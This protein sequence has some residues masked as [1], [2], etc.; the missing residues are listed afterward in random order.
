[1]QNGR[2]VSM[3]G[4]CVSGT[5]HFGDQGSQKIRTGTHRFGT[6]RH[7]TKITVADAGTKV[8]DVNKC[9][10]ESCGLWTVA[11]RVTLS[12]PPLVFLSATEE[13]DREAQAH[14]AIVFL[15]PIENYYT[16]LGLDSLA[17]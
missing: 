14:T 5:I 9:L 13:T 6:S 16:A 3:Q 11:G 10:Y 7:P 1:M 4:H 17:P 15:A 12:S 2:D 8:D